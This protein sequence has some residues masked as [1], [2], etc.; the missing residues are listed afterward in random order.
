MEKEIIS[1]ENG[2]CSKAPIIDR[3]ADT[4]FNSESIVE[5][6]YD[7]EKKS[8]SHLLWFN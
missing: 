4:F 8:R 5:D 2:K 7:F 3:H 1:C 6:F